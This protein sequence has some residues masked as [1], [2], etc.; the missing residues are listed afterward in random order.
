MMNMNGKKTTTIELEVVTMATVRFSGIEHIRGKFDLHVHT[1]ASDGVY[2]PEQIVR[3]AKSIGLSTIAITDHDTLDGLDRALQEAIYY[4]VQIIPG[5]ELSTKYKGI[6]IDILGYNIE[7][8]DE[9]N[10]V[11]NKLREGREERA[12]RIIERFCQFGMQITIEEVK[13]FSKGSVI[14]RPHIAAAIVQRGYVDTIQ[15]VFDNYLA[16]GKPCSVTKMILTPDQGIELIQRSG[17]IAVL[18]HPVLIDDNQLVVELLEK[19]TFDGIEVWH[20][21]HSS[22]DNEF[23]SSLSE[24]FGLF[25]TGGSDFHHD[26]HELGS[27]GFKWE[28]VSNYGS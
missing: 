22:K 26:E 7:Q 15:D 23:Y 14:A 8:N 16:D 13:E 24:R 25:K 17:G 6:S 9:L 12:S 10:D 2:E 11:L 27:F 20:R 28:G 5:V 18:A 21:K 4:G 1:T 19:F 3:K